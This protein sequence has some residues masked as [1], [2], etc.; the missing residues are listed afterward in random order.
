MSLTSILSDKCNKELRDKLKI[1]FL[2]PVFSLKTEIKAL[3]LTN[4]YGIVGTAFDYLMRFHLQYYNKT[5]LSKI[6]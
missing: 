1:E 3:P 5:H 4:N 6:K 2:R